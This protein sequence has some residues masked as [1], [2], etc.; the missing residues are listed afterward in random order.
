MKK[1]ILLLTLVLGIGIAFFATKYF[2][3]EKSKP[4]HGQPSD[5]ASCSMSCCLFDDIKLK[6]RQKEAIQSLEREYCQCRDS[7]SAQ[8]DRKRSALTDILLQTEPD[9]TTI[10]IQL[11]EIARLQTE[12]EKKTII[13]ILEVKKHLTPEQQERFIKPI[14]HEMRKRCQHG[15]LSE[16][17]QESMG[18]K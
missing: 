17:P 1:L 7:L 14:V 15:G 4:S 16:L 3:P 5:V 18:V 13:H 10:D 11:R 9:I 12:L 6:T 8:I 2:S